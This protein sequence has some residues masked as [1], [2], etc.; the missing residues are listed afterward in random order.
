MLEIKSV[1]GIQGSS[2]EH[3]TGLESPDDEFS[4]KLDAWVGHLQN[5]S[6][7]RSSRQTNDYSDDSSESYDDTNPR[8][9]DVGVTFIPGINNDRLMAARE[10]VKRQESKRI[11]NTYA[12]G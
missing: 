10:Q 11:M 6:F 8:L 2:E 12:R 7:K 4:T 9:L 5:K 1:R 3:R